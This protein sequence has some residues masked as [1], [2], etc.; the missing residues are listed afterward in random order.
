MP[1]PAGPCLVAPRTSSSL[2]STRANG[3]RRRSAGEDPGGVASE[4]RTLRRTSHGHPCLTST[5]GWASGPPGRLPWPSMAGLSRC[6]RKE[7]E[8]WNDRQIC[9]QFP[10]PPEL[11]VSVF[12]VLRP[13]DE[14]TGNIH[15][16]AELG[17]QPEAD[18]RYAEPISMRLLI[19]GIQGRPPAL[20][21]VV[22]P[23][24]HGRGSVARPSIRSIRLT[25][26]PTA[27]RTPSSSSSRYVR[28]AGSVAA[29]SA[30]TRPRAKA[31]PARIS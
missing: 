8:G 31:I 25:A 30:P 11:F 28:R 16:G 5:A 19:R 6:P 23:R 18:S 15:P 24:P 27:S 13:L 12:G 7:G 2:A 29:A 4:G 17:E 3:D 21:G 9:H 22:P 10:Q 26:I 14:E 1:P 20:R